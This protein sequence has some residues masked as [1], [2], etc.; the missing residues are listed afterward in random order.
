MILRHETG[1]LLSLR[2][3]NRAYSSFL[4]VFFLALKIA[5][6]RSHPRCSCEPSCL[7]LGL[8]IIRQVGPTGPPPDE[9]VVNQT[10]TFAIAVDHLDHPTVTGVFEFSSG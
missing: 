8:V 5:F 3:Q 7:F 9:G 6:A 10:L 2:P 4:C 1:A